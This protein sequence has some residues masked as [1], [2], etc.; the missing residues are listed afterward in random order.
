MKIPGTQP[1]ISPEV[2]QYGRDRLTHKSDIWAL[3]CI[4]YELYTGLQLFENVDMLESYI[5]NTGF[6][7]SYDTQ[8]VL[9][10][11][12][13]PW[14]YKILSDCLVI[15]PDKRINVSTLLDLI[16]P[17]QLS[18]SDPD[19]GLAHAYRWK[20]DIN[21]EIPVL[22]ELVQK[23]P[24]SSGFTNIAEESRPREHIHVEG[25]FSETDVI[26]SEGETTFTSNSKNIVGLP[27]VN[28]SS[29]SDLEERGYQLKADVNEPSS[30]LPSLDAIEDT[31]SPQDK[32]RVPL[33]IGDIQRPFPHE[34]IAFRN[35]DDDITSTFVINVPEGLNVLAK[36][37]FEA[38]ESFFN[39]LELL[40]TIDVSVGL[41]IVPRIARLF[42]KTD[43]KYFTGM[44]P[45]FPLLTG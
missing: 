2:F 30:W 23:D 5:R 24:P 22:R 10:N 3:G 41:D 39:E 17:G 26:M 34:K 13:E 16:G 15:D 7:S 45:E 20:G 12:M 43:R 8:V 36:L 6:D 14:T 27:T 42:N 33:N 35:T 19:R 9:M 32:T 18:P 28:S 38:P 29:I 44:V 31:M 1:Y 11:Q 4:G 25:T 37:L 21:L 40:E